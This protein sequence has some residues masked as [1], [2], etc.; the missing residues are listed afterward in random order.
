MVLG[1]GKQA[2]PDLGAEEPSAP[3]GYLQILKEQMWE[4]EDGQGGGYSCARE[5]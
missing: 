4:A 1:T 2:Q 5:L 3:G